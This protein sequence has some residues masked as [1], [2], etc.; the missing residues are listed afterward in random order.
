[1]YYNII[2]RVANKPKT[3][4]PAYEMTPGFKPFT[5]MIKFVS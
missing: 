1:M 4:K 5:R 2:I 3:T